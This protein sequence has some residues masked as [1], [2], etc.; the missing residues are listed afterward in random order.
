MADAPSM[1]TAVRHGLAPAARADARLLILGSLPGEA[2]LAAQRYY[3]YPRN[4]FWRL[5]GRVLGEPL[6]E[7]D[8]GE[9]L[10]RLQKRRVALWDVIHAA[11]RQGSLDQRLR[12]VETRDLAA[13]VAGL[14]DL[15][16]VAFNGA[17]AATMGR[18]AL[19]DTALALIDLPSSSPANTA[20]FDQKAQCW[21]RLRAVLD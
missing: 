2:S 7:L 3:A 12:E 10:S 15:R 11:R 9:R 19:G 21:D 1:T 17:T 8:Y 13:F 5:V 16:A 4:Q 20:A 18:K 6:A 14:P